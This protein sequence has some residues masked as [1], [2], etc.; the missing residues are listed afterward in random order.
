MAVHG[1][2]SGHLSPTEVTRLS[3]HLLV[4]QVDVL[5]QHVL[6]QVLLITCGTCP[7][8]PHCWEKIGFISPDVN[9]NIYMT[10]LCAFILFS[11]ILATLQ[12]TTSGSISK[13]VR[14]FVK[15]P[16]MFC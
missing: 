9:S 12:A 6:R 1:G 8:L 2:A 10:K 15:G 13:L 7:R 5:L 3:F 4:S 16:E 11:M 14:D